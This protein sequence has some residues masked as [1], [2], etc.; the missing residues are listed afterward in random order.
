MFSGSVAEYPQYLTRSFFSNIFP[1]VPK[2]ELC[3]ESLF[4]WGNRDSACVTAG[5]FFFSP[6]LPY[7]TYFLEKPWKLVMLRDLVSMPVGRLWALPTCPGQGF[8]LF[9]GAS[10]P[11]VNG[12]M[13]G[14]S[15]EVELSCTL[16]HTGSVS[17]LAGAAFTLLGS[18]DE[19]KGFY[20]T[21]WGSLQWPYGCK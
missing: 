11:S 19:S 20:R 8:L 17:E 12:G 5:G 1:C 2:W 15:G 9:V 18:C 10:H 16:C 21:V 14:W 13:C 3:A 6:L 4:I 7:F